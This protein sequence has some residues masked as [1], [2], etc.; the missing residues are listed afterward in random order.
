VARIELVRADV[1]A[2]RRNRVDAAAG[3]PCDDPDRDDPINPVA[4]RRCS[5]SCASH[6]GVSSTASCCQALSLQS[7]TFLLLL[8]VDGCGSEPRDQVGGAL[9][10]AGD[11]GGRGSEGLAGSGRPAVWGMTGHREE[12]DGD[13]EREASEER[14]GGGGVGAGAGV[15]VA[16]GSISG[17]RWDE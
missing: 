16:S 5:I 11:D 9:R 3:L 2:V 15:D 13:S 12:G 7:L 1:P 8:D 10:P 6:T 4:R 14:G 17:S